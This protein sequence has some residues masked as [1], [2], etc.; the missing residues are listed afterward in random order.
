[1]AAAGKGSPTVFEAETAIAFLSY[2][3]QNCDFVVLECGLG[4]SLDATNIIDNTTCAVFTSISLD[5]LGV[6]GNT[7]EEI[8]ENKAGIIKP[9]CTVIS[10]PQSPQ[11][12]NILTKR[13]TISGMSNLFCRQK[14]HQY[15]KRK[16]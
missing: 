10:A 5:H 11:V 13:A 8:A 4:G 9:G 3:E 6:I 16:L 7:L 2:K 1:M 15:H 14:T 12:K